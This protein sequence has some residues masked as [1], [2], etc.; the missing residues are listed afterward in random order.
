VQVVFLLLRHWKEPLESCQAI[1]KTLRDEF[2]LLKLWFI[3]LTESA[4]SELSSDS[5]LDFGGMALW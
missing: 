2:C 4:M 3:L 5:E 1:E